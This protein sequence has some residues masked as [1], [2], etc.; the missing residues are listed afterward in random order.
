MYLEI[1]GVLNPIKFPPF[2]LAVNPAGITGVSTGE[3][4]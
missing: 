4:R 2:P 1:L 3:E